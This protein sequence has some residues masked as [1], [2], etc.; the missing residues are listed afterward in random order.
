VLLPRFSLASSRHTTTT[1]ATEPHDH[2]APPPPVATASRAIAKLIEG[3]SAEQIR[4][5]FRLPDDL[6]EEEKLE[7]IAGLAGGTCSHR[8]INYI[9]CLTLLGSLAGCPDSHL[10]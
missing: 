8:L 6:S 2:P 3:K 5:T 9:A 4:E 1:S 7:P 10:W